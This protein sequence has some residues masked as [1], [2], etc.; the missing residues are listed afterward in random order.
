M[1]YQPREDSE[2]LKK[3]VKQFAKGLVLDMGTGSGIQAETAAKKREVKTV[4]A[5]DINPEA[6]K[7]IQ[8]KKVKFIHSDLFKKI[9]KKRFNTI[10]FNPPYLPQ[11]PNIEDPSLYGG[12]QGFEILEK[13]LNQINTYLEEDGIVLIVFSNFTQKNI[14]DFILEKNLLQFKLL[15]KQKLPLFEELYCYLIKKTQTLKHLNKKVKEIKYLAHGKRGMIFTANYRKK[16]IAIKVKKRS[17]EAIGRIQNEIK[18]LEQLNKSKIGPKLLFHNKNY[19][20]Y[21][22]IPGEF[23]IDFIKNN[24]KTK[25][26]K[27]IKNVFEQCFILDL[28]SINKE[29]M[30]RPLKH[31]IIKY[32]KVTLIDFERTHIAKKPHNVTQFIQFITYLLKL[33]KTKMRKLAQEYKQ[34]MTKKNFQKIINKIS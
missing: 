18:W 16:K 30:H 25:V 10:I 3:Y 5:V 28:L 9:P 31:I 15:E 14:V 13:F 2:L 19:L 22:F 11:D 1:I 24:P 20:A 34:Q 21:E 26:K 23:I 8:H 17:S 12:K 33:N 27:V 4:I 7:Y 32:P 6:K 29:E